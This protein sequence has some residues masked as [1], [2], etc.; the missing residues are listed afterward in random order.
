MF[1]TE[2]ISSDFLT[3]SSNSTTRLLKYLLSNQIGQIVTAL[4]ENNMFVLHYHTRRHFS[5]KPRNFSVT[6][7]CEKN[8]AE[9]S[10]ALPVVTL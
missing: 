3:I 2:K 8:F 6:G 7:H 5:Q 1:R 10:H 9:F 4:I